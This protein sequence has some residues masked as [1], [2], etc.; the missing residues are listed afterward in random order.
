MAERP[1]EQR[2]PLEDRSLAEI[3]MARAWLTSLRDGVVYK[4]DGLSSEQLRWKPTP[5][6][7]SLGTLVRHLGLAERLW[8]RV[9][10]SGEDMD[11]AWRATMF[12]DFP[13]EWSHADLVAFYRAEV[14]AADAA[15][16][17]CDDF[18][19]P[20]LDADRPTTWRWAVTHMIEETA[21]H[22]GHMDITRELLDG[23]TGR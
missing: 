16:D 8:F 20:A 19:R 14:A 18:D 2:A 15:I 21:R 13:A 9:I 4:I 12:D 6:A 17:A 10:L 11:M 3:P 7:N 22:L 23:Q 5:S 1:K